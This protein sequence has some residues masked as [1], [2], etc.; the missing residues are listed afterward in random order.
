MEL[1][2]FFDSFKPQS[3]SQG[4]LLR[5]F[6]GVGQLQK[7][8]TTLGF[9]PFIISN[10]EMLD[11]ASLCKKVFDIHSS[12]ENRSKEWHEIRFRFLTL[13]PEYRKLASI[14]EEELNELDEKELTLLWQTV[15]ML[16]RKRIEQQ[17][18]FM[19]AFAVTIEL[20]KQVIKAMKSHQPSPVEAYR[21]KI[22][23]HYSELMKLELPEGSTSMRQALSLSVV[24]IDNYLSRF[25]T[26]QEVYADL[27]KQPKAK[28]SPE[29]AIP[30]SSCS[31]SKEPIQSDP[32]PV[33]MVA[34]APVGAD[35]SYKFF[36]N[37]D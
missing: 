22:L 4:D 15:E 3:P 32:T 16:I 21:T 29:P 23:T 19:K 12:P 7:L 26:M 33:V 17:T 5:L 1:L 30:A 18:K 2:Q 34:P 9:V 37:Q 25:N 27:I 11:A 13:A 24:E 8:T 6:S 20:A 28:N 14:S 36:S 31:S 10:L 35:S